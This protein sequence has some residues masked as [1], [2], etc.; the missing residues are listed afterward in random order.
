M[1]KFFR[2]IRQR[3]LKE[4]QLSTYLLYAIGEI[5]LVVIG[6]LI[7]LQINNWNEER[8]AKKEEISTLK[9]L[10]SEFSSNEV[11]F[12]E[13]ITIKRKA[14]DGWKQFLLD[15][16]NNDFEAIE[17]NIFGSWNSASRTTNLT[18]ITLK[19]IMDSG[20]IDKIENDS[21]K[22]LLLSWENIFDE[23]KEEELWHIDFHNNQMRPY[24]S[25]LFP[26]P[27]LDYPEER[28]PLLYSR[29]STDEIFKKA[30]RKALLDMKYR[31]LLMTNHSRLAVQVDEGLIVEQTIDQIIR[32]LQDEI[33]NKSK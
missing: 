26:I 14:R 28:D 19:S 12:N 7:A 23:Y 17:Q 20:R 29:L 25:S 22:N 30:Y 8:K 27:R 21:L 16:A 31:N 10:M 18:S 24:E 4:G 33:Q 1:L 5:L 9:E 6:I 15:L 32:L 11:L 3:L 2:R 13:T